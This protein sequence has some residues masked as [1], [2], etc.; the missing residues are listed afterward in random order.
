[1]IRPEGYVGLPLGRKEMEIYLHL[2][3]DTMNVAEMLTAQLR[4]IEIV[5]AHERVGA[6]LAPR[7][8]P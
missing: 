6:T 3:H 8:M 4:A 7:A 2:L 5:A 1:M